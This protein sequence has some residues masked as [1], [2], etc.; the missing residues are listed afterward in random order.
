MD[1]YTILFHCS[2]I[3]LDLKTPG[4]K[5]KDFFSTK[6]K[7]QCKI[8]TSQHFPYGC[9]H[10][11]CLPQ[12]FRQLSLFTFHDISSDLK[13]AGHKSEDIFSPE[14]NFQLEIK[15]CPYG[16]D[17]MSVVFLSGLDKV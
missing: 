6:D 5:S 1:C 17:N 14:D 9:L 11:C 13:T 3:F 2:H 4:H 7:F 10:I 15:T 16:F 8:K 12:W